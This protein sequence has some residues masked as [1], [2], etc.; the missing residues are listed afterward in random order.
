MARASL[1]ID[2]SRLPLPLPSSSLQRE[3]RV[4]AAH[5]QLEG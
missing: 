5:R 1:L 2:S 4:G 3:G